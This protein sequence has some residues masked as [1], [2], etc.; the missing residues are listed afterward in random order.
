[1]RNSPPPG[2]RRDEGVKTRFRLL[3]PILTPEYAA[4]RIVDA[5]RRDRRRLIMPRL[6]YVTW[7]GRLL[8]V[9]LFDAIMEFLGVNR[10]MDDFVGRMDH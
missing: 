8:P 9:R 10:S 4:D 6:V 2:A 7:L 3:L 1:M 5:I